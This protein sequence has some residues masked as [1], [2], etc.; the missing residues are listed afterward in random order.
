M[1]PSYHACGKKYNFELSFEVDIYQ[2]DFL[3]L[4]TVGINVHVGLANDGIAMSPWMTL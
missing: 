3:V 4:V 1:L 2:N